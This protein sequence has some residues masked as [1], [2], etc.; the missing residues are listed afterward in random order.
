MNPSE[1]FFFTDAEAAQFLR[2][3]LVTNW[4]YRKA[5]II[6]SKPLS[7]RT[8]DERLFLEDWRSRKLSNV[9]AL[10][11]HDEFIVREQDAELAEMVMHGTWP[12]DLPELTDAPW[13]RSRQ[14]KSEA[15]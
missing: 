6:D 10:T 2:Q 3:S 11:V 5:R 13:N 15:L 4:R 7:Q 1:Q 9:P 12:E 8:T 14:T